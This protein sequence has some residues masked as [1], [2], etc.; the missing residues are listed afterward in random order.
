LSYAEHWAALATQIKSLQRAGELY[1]LFQS[2]HTEDSYG[3]GEFLRE[4]CGVLVQSL[5]QFRSD[6]A[7]SLPTTA[8]ARIDHFLGTALVQAAKDTSTHQRGARAALVGLAALEAETTFLLAG[9][10]EQI[11]ARAERALLHLQ[12]IL[13]V[14]PDVSAKWK[15][16]FD[17]NEVACERLGSVH[18]LSHGIYAFKVDA[19]GARTDL[20]FN[21]P[22]PDALLAQAVEG[23]VLTEWKVAKDAKAATAAVHQAR[24]QADLYSQ[25]A[26]AGLELRSHRYIVV[27]TPTELRLDTLGLGDRTADG[28]TYRLVNIAIKPGKP[29]AVSKALARQGKT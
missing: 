1:G 8:A 21:E 9:R 3:V 20:V 24:I 7:G 23:M 2:Y 4:Q 13:A 5:E 12:R 18:L 14:D 19:A 29:S 26:L 17:K 25:G 16:A 10:Q 22:P 11:R 15:K 28:V 27:V 6:F